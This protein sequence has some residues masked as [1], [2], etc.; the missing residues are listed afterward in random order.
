MKAIRFSE[1]FKLNKSQAELDFVDVF[2]NDD[3]PL[4]IDPYVF[5]LRTDEWSMD[6]NDLIVD[7]FS[8]VI[9]AI[10]NKRTVYAKQ[11]LE[12]LGEP[13]ETHMGVS[14][15][16]TSGKGVSGKQA[17]DLYERLS[18]SKAV[19]SGRVTDISDCELMIPGIGFDKVSDITTNIIRE[20]LISYTQE[21]CRLHGIP[22]RLV[23]SG[24]IWSPV[25]KRW[26]NG[27][28][29][30]LPVY[31][32]KR[33]ILVP[34][35][36][37]VFK[38]ILS[39][40]ELYEKDIVEYIQAEQEQA[41]SSLVEVLKNGKRRVTKKSIKE[42]PDYKMSKEFIY[43]FCDQHP[44]VLEQYKQRKGDGVTA[45]IDIDDINEREVAKS[46]IDALHS[47]AVGGEQASDFHALSVGVLEF[48]FFPYL[49]YPK[50]E[51]EVHDG[52]KRID[53]TFNNASTEGFWYQ[54]RTAPK[55]AASL[56]MVECKN[57][58]RDIKNPELDQLAGR[59][60]HQRGW[61]GLI[62]C[63]G[64]DNKK[65]FVQRC[66]DTAADGRGIIICLDDKDVISMLQMVIDGKRSEVDKYMV[67][68]YQEVIS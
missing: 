45:T 46:L 25:E 44:E 58:T 29:V 30:E 41:M 17:N 43:A 26:L 3:I 20:K 6:C 8:T 1:Y 35:Y 68:R 18:S 12:Q 4:Y 11:L 64:F 28:Y 5:K 24:K 40:R 23:P 50:K 59:F 7:F 53:I 60:S 49:V 32:G 33:I 2:V 42:H 38:M 54:V 51:H 67:D 55:I 16:S 19:S 14:R 57:Y 34:K 13:R 48:L 65:L 63:R 15:G 31:N 52:R 27:T 62:M 21:Q 47:I 22:M 36:S 37:V 66:K 56:V 61:F 10:K 9:N 39:S